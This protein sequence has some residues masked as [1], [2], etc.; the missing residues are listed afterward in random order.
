MEGNEE[1]SK[2]DFTFSTKIS[3]TNEKP[4]AKARRISSKKAGRGIS[5]A[6]KIIPKNTTTKLCCISLF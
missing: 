2:G 4:M 6:A 1:S 3:T 5:I